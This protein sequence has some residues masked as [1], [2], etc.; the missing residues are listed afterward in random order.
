LY[1]SELTQESQ[2]EDLAPVPITP[3]AT[4][5]DIIDELLADTTFDVSASFYFPVEEIPTTRYRTSGQCARDYRLP[6]VQERQPVF[7]G[8]PQSSEEHAEIYRKL[9]DYSWLYE[10]EDDC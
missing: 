6:S 9:L 4:Q 1:I 8:Q 5:D 3:P 7:V 2:D 10:E